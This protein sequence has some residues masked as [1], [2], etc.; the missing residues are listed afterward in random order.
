MPACPHHIHVAL[1]TRAY[2][3]FVGPGLLDQVGTRAAALFP[4]TKRA[5][6]V[7][8]ANT[9]P[10]YAGCALASLRDAGLHADLITVPAGETSKSL[11]ACGA[12]LSEMA[13]AGLDRKSF[14]VALGGGVIGDLAGFCAAI[15]QRG[16]PYI[17][18]PTTLLSMVDSSV[19]GKTGVNLPE[20]KNLV[21]AFHQ[22]ALVLADTGTLQTLPP[23]VRNEG[24][25]EIIKHAAIRDAAMFDDIDQ[26]ATSQGDLAALIARNI[27]IKARI[28]EE[29]EFET[30][31]TRALLNFGHTLGHAIEAAAGYGGEGG[32]LHGEAIALGL[33]AAAWLSMQKAGL[34]AADAG[35]IT[36]ALAAYGLPLVLP[37]NPCFSNEALVQIARSDKKYDQG[38][39]RFVLL[40]ALG[41]AFVSRDLSETD[42][43]DALNHLR[44]A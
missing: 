36:R 5:A 44:Q 7:C 2:D 4:S 28:V 16:I 13:R 17:Q 42:L 23:A 29:D 21:G 6:V 38:R 43:I 25:A 12:V 20:A 24:F 3:V 34:P 41:D 37:D 19:G 32:Y 35:R 8:D 40:R 14:L 31:G 26:A 1:G 9:A 18:L 11:A 33:R 39:V 10:L 22:P 30:I 15:Y 27:A